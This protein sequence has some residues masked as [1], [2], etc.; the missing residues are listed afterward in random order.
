MPPL[1]FGTASRH[2]DVIRLIDSRAIR[3]LRAANNEISTLDLTREQKIA[4]WVGVGVVSAYLITRWIDGRH[5]T[6]DEYRTPENLRRLVETVRRV[7]ALPP[8]QG[9]FS[10]F[11]RVEAYARHAQTFHVPLP[12]D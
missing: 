2:G 1:T 10:P 3:A 4:I 12:E 5:W 8:I 7:H 6:V 9:A 11:R